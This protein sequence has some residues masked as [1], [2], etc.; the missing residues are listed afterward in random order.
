MGIRT[1][2]VSKLIQKEV[3]TLLQ[4]PFSGASNS[5]LTVTGAR[6]TP[7]LSIAYVYVSVLGDP[8]AR[9]AAFNRLA[10]SSS[11]IRRALASRIRHQ[12]RI[13]P[14]IR[15]FLDESLDHAKKIE[16]LFDQIR[17]ERS[18]SHLPDESEEQSS[19]SPDPKD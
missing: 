12:V 2:R 11:E 16:S 9:Q 18:E 6:V 1:D 15:F 13:I 7:D 4:G 10:D 14:D 8:A 19:E 17:S 5:L 3:A